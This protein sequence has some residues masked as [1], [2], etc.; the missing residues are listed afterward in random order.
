MSTCVCLA[1]PVWR[2]KQLCEGTGYELPVCL[3]AAFP[4]CA[5]AIYAA[6][7]STVTVANSSMANN[8]VLDYTAPSSDGGAAYVDGRAN[9]TFFDTLIKGNRA[10]G[11]R[12]GGVMMNSKRWAGCRPVYQTD[13]KLH[14]RPQAAARHI[15]FHNSMLCCC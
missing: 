7:D 4:P 11:G 5:G 9:L 12:G 8:Y 1:H 10:L 3:C 13:L 2:P 6:G 14:T 15:R